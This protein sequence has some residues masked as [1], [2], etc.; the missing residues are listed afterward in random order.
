MKNYRTYLGEDFKAIHEQEKKALNESKKPLTEG[1]KNWTEAYQLFTACAD[2]FFPDEDK[3]REAAQQVYEIFKGDPEVE[4]AWKRWNDTD[5]VKEYEETD[6]SLTEDTVKQNSFKDFNGK[7]VDELKRYLDRNKIKY[8][9]FKEEE[10]FP[11]TIEIFDNSLMNEEP[12]VVITIKDNKVVDID[13]SLT[14][15]TVKQDGKWV[16]KGKEGTHGEFKTKKEADKQRA[17]MFANGF[18]K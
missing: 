7:S 14:E 12:G 3:V 6:E 9:E 13:E 1:F 18:K 11:H 16:N 15:D 4:E 5:S 10:N 2:R 17:A 8:D